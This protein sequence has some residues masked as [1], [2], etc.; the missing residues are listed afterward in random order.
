MV[1]TRRIEAVHENGMLR[2]LEPL[3]LEEH[4]HVMVV[5]SEA[6]GVPGAATWTRTISPPLKRR[7]WQCA[8]SRRLRRFARSQQQIQT[9]G[10]TRFGPSGMSEANSAFD[11]E[12][13][14]SYNKLY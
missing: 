1:M 6:P 11:L 3:A 8:A 13:A 2:P 14:L 9:L 12:S 5:I 7:F 4:Q 10:P